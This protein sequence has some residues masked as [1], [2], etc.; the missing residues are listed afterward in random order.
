MSSLPVP[1]F[2]LQILVQLKRNNLSWAG[3]CQ[4]R[5]RGVA[6][7]WGEVCLTQIPAPCVP[8]ASTGRPDPSDHSIFKIWQLAVFFVPRT[9]VWWLLRLW[10]FDFL[11]VKIWQLNLACILFFKIH[12]KNMEEKETNRGQTNIRMGKTSW[13]A[14]FRY[15]KEGAYSTFGLCLHQRCSGQKRECHCN[16]VCKLNIFCILMSGINMQRSKLPES[17]WLNI[18]VHYSKSK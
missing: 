7:A 14:V 17:V 13:P 1:T 3:V 10:L 15:N 8:H 18:K 16:I 4:Q 2:S 5:S 9:Q 6:E 11:Q 12:A